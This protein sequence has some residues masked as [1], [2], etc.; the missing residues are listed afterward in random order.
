M[1]MFRC[2]TQRYGRL[3]ARW[4][5][6]PGTLLDLASFD[7]ERDALLDLCGGTGAV[8]L[9][10]IRRG[11]RHSPTLLDLEPRCP[12][13][14]IIS[15]RGDAHDP[16]SYLG[17]SVD[18]CTIRQSLGYLKLRVIFPMLYS[19]IRPHGRLALNTFLKPRWKALSYRYDG[20]TFYEASAV[21]GRS[22]LHV[23]ASPFIGAD[24][25]VFRHH[26]LEEI[27][28]SMSDSGF[29]IENVRVS[30]RSVRILATK[31]G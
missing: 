24:V 28:L 5:C 21:I 13:P 26:P 31:I 4:L 2:T 25:S 16:R 3:Y 6:N 10:A 27:I 14:S 8:S 30:G 17:V 22:V 1:I 18:L 19:V 15:V 23:Q 7:P 29:S 11:A 20:S 12:E 9:E